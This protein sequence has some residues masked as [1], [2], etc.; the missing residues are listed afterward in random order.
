MS[1]NSR[2]D[3]RPTQGLTDEDLETLAQLASGD[4]HPEET[5]H[6]TALDPDGR[7]PLTFPWRLHDGRSGVTLEQ[8]NAVRCA[9]A[10]GLPYS[11]IADR[12]SFLSGR[13]HARRHAL[14][15]CR[16][17]GD[18]PPIANGNSPGPPE[19]SVTPAECMDLNRRWNRDEFDTYADAGRW[20]DRAESV[21]WRHIN[22]KCS[23]G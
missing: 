14:G 13:D 15:D 1:T 19:G 5:A 7:D 21:A 12:F 23:H 3:D 8:C 9:A 6:D 4:L 11:R 17:S 18:V 20:L 22:G 10:D 2:S 16:H